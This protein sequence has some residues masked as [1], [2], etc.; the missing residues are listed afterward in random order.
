MGVVML[1]LSA[2]RYRT[3]SKIKIK[4]HDMG[5]RSFSV[6]YDC[7]IFYFFYFLIQF[8]ER[9]INIFFFKGIFASDLFFFYCVISNY[10]Y[11]LLRSFSAESL[12]PKI[13]VCEISNT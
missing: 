11:L 6:V 1:S 7:L 12:C 10:S 2:R 4:I 13:W 5:M 9:K 3:L 8:C